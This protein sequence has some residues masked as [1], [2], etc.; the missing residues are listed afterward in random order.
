MSVF[1]SLILVL[2]L[3]ALGY[4]G[5][6]IPGM[7]TFF[8]IFIPYAATAVFLAGVARRIIGWSNSPVPFRITATCGQ[9][10][11]LPWIKS[12]GIDNPSTAPGA[13]VRMALENAVSVAGVLLL[14]EATLTEI[15]D[16][17]PE[18]AESPGMM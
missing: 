8:G 12:N 4:L 10:K 16:E 18:R 9:Q 5:G 7:R 15:E 6:A 11:S 13:V 2:M 17:K 1:Y 3:G 14:A